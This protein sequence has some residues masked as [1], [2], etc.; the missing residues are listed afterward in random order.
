MYLFFK[1]RDFFFAL[2]TE[3]VKRVL[4]YD[5]DIL[6]DNHLIYEGVEYRLFFSSSF[7]QIK[8]KQEEYGKNILLINSKRGYDYAL[9]VEEV[10]GFFEL[11]DINVINKS[12]LLNKYGYQYIDFT[13]ILNEK[14]IFSFKNEYFDSR[15]EE[16]T[17][18]R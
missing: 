11:S 10:G 4:S 17:C 16:L 15:Y 13:T 14:L 6:K 7:F 8:E 12:E 18:Q 5:E 2:S 3:V 1:V 9:N